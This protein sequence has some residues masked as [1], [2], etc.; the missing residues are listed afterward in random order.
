M[1]TLAELLSEKGSC[2]SFYEGVCFQMLYENIW[3]KKG[4]LE[5]IEA[6][7][8]SF[9]FGKPIATVPHIHQNMVLSST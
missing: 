1:V 4:F 6:Q 8:Q 5:L 2:N 7:E 9:S 3:N